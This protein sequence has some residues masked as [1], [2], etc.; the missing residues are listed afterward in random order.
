MSALP[1]RA[2]M[3]S[4]GKNVCLVPKVDLIASRR[5]AAC[6]LPSR[7]GSGPLIKTSF[8]DG[9]LRFVT[10][11]AGWI[12]LPVGCFFRLSKLA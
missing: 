4:V 7:I 12:F 8:L 1:L 2:D 5:L 10:A 6:R 9:M 3:L 11:I